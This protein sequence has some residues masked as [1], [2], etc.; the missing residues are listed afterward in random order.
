[1]G[2]LSLAA[3]SLSGGHARADQ[4]TINVA[5]YGGV[6]NDYLTNVFGKPFA[7]KTGIAVNF[8][9]DA[10]LALAKLQVASGSPAQWDIVVLTGADI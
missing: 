2:A 4:V 9:A 8:G 10:S 3:A 6:L 1:M 5:G 7:E